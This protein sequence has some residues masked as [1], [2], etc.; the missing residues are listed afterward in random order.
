MIQPKNDR[1]LVKMLPDTRS[2]IIE[3]PADTQTRLIKGEVL[4]VGPKVRSAIA[5]GDCVLFTQ[6]CV[7]LKSHRAI[8]KDELLIQD[9]DLAGMIDRTARVLDGASP[10]V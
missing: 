2:D 8:A 7:E 9:G 6:A 10:R 1:L 3:T 5:V 4:A